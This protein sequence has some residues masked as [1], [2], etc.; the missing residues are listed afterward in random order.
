MSIALSLAELE[1][2]DPRAP[3]RRGERRFLCPLC[4]DGKSRDAAHRSLAL[5]TSTGAWVC[6]RC[7]ARGLLKENQTTRP[8][9]SRAARSQAALERAFALSSRTED[10]DKRAAAADPHWRAMWEAS[11]PLE[12]TPGAA[13]IEGRAL[14][15]DAAHEAC[16][17]FS[18]KWYGRPA[19][20]FPVH[21]RV[22][23][24]V[25]VNG[26][27]VAGRANPKTQTAGAQSLGVFAT[28]GALSAPLVAVCEAPLDA[29]S[30]WL[31]GVASIALIGTSAPDWLSSALAFR[32]VLM[33][34]DA[35][36]AGDNTAAKLSPLLKS[37]GARTFRFRAR[38]GK[39]WS[40]LLERRG[41]ANLR[42][43]IIPF[44]EMADDEVRVDAAWS[45]MKSDHREAA[46]FIAWLIADPLTRHLFLERIRRAS[47]T[48]VA[49]CGSP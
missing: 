8:A 42:E 46:E 16:V 23:A 2:Y 17:R 43:H 4:G 34:T 44:S 13:Y 40:E 3:R 11:T 30:L 48:A 19:V 9:L 29:L 25:A 41:A 35:D 32:S 6:H 10:P 18:A 5:N 1:A 31:C 14:P 7:S 24:L 22:G 49:E 33:A 27:F 21:D 20:L 26:R 15:A 36:T 37:R 28:P 47:L 38:G 39:D 12:G 45:L